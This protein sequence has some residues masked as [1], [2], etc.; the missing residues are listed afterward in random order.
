[1]IARASARTTWCK[2]SKMLASKYY[3]HGRHNTSSESPAHSPTVIPCTDAALAHQSPRSVY[4]SAS[5]TT[6][7]PRI[8]AHTAWSGPKLAQM[9]GSSCSSKPCERSTGSTASPPPTYAPMFTVPA[10]F[11]AR[12]PYFCNHNVTRI[13]PLRVTVAHHLAK[14]P[15]HAPTLCAP[16]PPSAPGHAMHHNHHH[17]HTLAPAESCSAP[18]ALARAFCCAMSR[19]SRL[20]VTWPCKGEDERRVGAMLPVGGASPAT[21]CPRTLHPSAAPSSPA[22]QAAQLLRPAPEPPPGTAP[23]APSAIPSPQAPC[24]PRLVSLPAGSRR[25]HLHTALRS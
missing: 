9:H 24:P 20:S 14:P 25:A 21:P 23:I 6:W 17:P 11:P 15:L 8:G 19:H 5:C 2:K 4:P 10:R 13:W 7:R 12:H 18:H 1:M 22:A 16:L 3:A